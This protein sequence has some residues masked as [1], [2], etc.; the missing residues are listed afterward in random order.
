[1]FDHIYNIFNKINI[2]YIIL[3]IINH[4]Y[5]FPYSYFLSISFIFNHH[6]FISPFLYYHSQIIFL[7]SHS[8]VTLF[9]IY[10]FLNNII[11]FIPLLI[12]TIILNYLSIT[13]N[14]SILKNMFNYHNIYIYFFKC[15]FRL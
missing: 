12:F 9:F 6:L 4:Y 15:I 14:L 11:S 2:I 13:S 7:F 5:R 3:K 10:L 1:M 8:P